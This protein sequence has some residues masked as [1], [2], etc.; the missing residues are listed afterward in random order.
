M[1]TKNMTALRWS[2][3]TLGATVTFVL[4]SNSHYAQLQSTAQAQTASPPIT[5]ADKSAQ[6]VSKNQ[7][8]Q[9]AVQ[10]TPNTTEQP[11]AEENVTQDKL[12]ITQ[13]AY[14]NEIPAGESDDKTDAM[15]SLTIRSGDTFTGILQDLGALRSFGDILPLGTEIKPLLNLQT[16][17]TLRVNVQN[18]ELHKLIYEYSDRKHFILS[19]E[20][21]S[22]AVENRT[23][24]IESREAFANAV[25][26]DS[27]YLTA[28]KAGLD[29]E[30]IIETANLL[31]WDI[32]FILDIREND[33]FSVLYMEEYL[34]GEK[35]GNGEIIGVKFINQGKT[36]YALRHTL[37][38]GSS[39]YFSADG[40]NVKKPFLRSPLEFT[41]VSSSFNPQR[42]HPIL[43]IVRPHRGVDYAAPAGTPIS[44]SGDGKVIFRG[45]KSGYGNTVILRH[46]GNYSTLYAHLSQFAKSARLNASV[47]QGQTIGYVGMTGY[48]TGPHLH[49]E[50]R[51]NGIHQNPL[52][53]KLPD[54][55]PLQAGQL[56][57]FKQAAAPFMRKLDTLSRVNVAANN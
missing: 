25:I 46:G 7:N 51:I 45:W 29:D 16:G 52:K 15:S 37:A 44:A 19:R 41:R 38:D 28:K 6:P 20:G 30:I 49:Y 43:N 26:D 39:E 53:V 9:N 18:N 23:L 2:G 22:Y 11:D 48:A 56:A 31:A 50:F 57:A 4:F 27:F 3:L 12:P 54:S 21:D 32:D 17:K 35:I 5:A 34:H 24:P 40:R 47:K 33:S 10:N 42:L 55:K 8:T 36:H 13:L 14:Y 1:Q